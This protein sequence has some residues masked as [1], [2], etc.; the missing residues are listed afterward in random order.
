MVSHGFRIKSNLLPWPA[1]TAWSPCP[2]SLYTTNS[3]DALLVSF[4]CLEPANLFATCWVLRKH[5]PLLLLWL[6][7]FSAFRSQF[8]WYICGGAFYLKLAFI[9]I[10]FHGTFSNLKWSCWFIWLLI[11]YLSPVPK[12]QESYLPLC[13]LLFVLYL[14]TVEMNCWAS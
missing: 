10:F 5:F 12:W 14:S 7:L 3:L 2:T 11:L 9:Y 4:W 13:F 8:K 1:D 6:A